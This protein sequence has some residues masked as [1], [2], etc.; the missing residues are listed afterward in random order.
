MGAGHFDDL[1]AIAMRLGL[2]LNS[3]QGGKR[4]QRRETIARCGWLHTAV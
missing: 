1:F 2:L 3:G 4:P